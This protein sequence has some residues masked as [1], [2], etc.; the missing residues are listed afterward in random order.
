MDTNDHFTAIK[1]CLVDSD[2]SAAHTV[3]VDIEAMVMYTAVVV[4]E[5]IALDI[6]VAVIAVVMGV[7]TEAAVTEAVAIVKL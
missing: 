6:A 4:I 1:D 3:S 2:T 7:D 5:A